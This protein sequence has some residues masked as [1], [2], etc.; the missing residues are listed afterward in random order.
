MGKG[1][2]KNNK[3]ATKPINKAFYKIKKNK[4]II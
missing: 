2:K 4:I 3:R 1:H